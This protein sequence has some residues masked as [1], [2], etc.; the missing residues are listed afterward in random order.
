MD[1]S[2]NTSQKINVRVQPKTGGGQDARLD[3]PVTFTVESGDATV[4]QDADGLG[5]YII[6]GA[7]GPSVIR[8]RGDADLTGGERLIEDVVNLT[9]TDTEA[10]TLN[11]Q[12]GTPE[13]K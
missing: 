11:L 2:I 12:A 4:Q 6:S 9:V 7:A 3:G 1:L 13:P 10:E 8:V 5:A